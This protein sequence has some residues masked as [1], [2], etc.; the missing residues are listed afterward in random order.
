MQP[1]MWEPKDIARAE[2]WL[3]IIGCS[4]VVLAGLLFLFA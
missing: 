2:K 3:L 4:P 1:R